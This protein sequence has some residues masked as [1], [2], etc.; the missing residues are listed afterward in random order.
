MGWRMGAFVF[1]EYILFQKL[2]DIDAPAVLFFNHS[3][4]GG[5]NDYLLSE[6][7]KLLAQDKKCIELAYDVYTSRYKVRIDYKELK[8][9]RHFRRL[10]SAIGK[11]NKADITDICINELVSY[12]D[13]YSVLHAAA[14]LKDFCRAKLIMLLHDYYSICPTIN[15]LRDDCTYCGLECGSDEGCLKKNRYVSGS[16]Y[17]DIVQW[18]DEWGKFLAGCDSIIA[19]SG[20]SKKIMEKAYG[21]LDN[22][23][24][25]PHRTGQMLEV[26][27]KRKITNDINIGILGVLSDRKGLR[28]VKDM[29][30]IIN[31][32]GLAVNIILIGT[33]EEEIA[34]GKFLETGKYTREQLPGLM[35][36]YDIDVVFIASVWPET[37]SYTAEEAMKMHMPVAVF[38]LGAP[39]ERISVYDNGLLI[40]RIDPGYALKKIM[41]FAGEKQYA[42]PIKIKVLFIIE[43]ESF[44]SRYRVD[45]LREHLAHIGIASELAFI[46]K[47]DINS[48]SGYNAVSIYRCTDVKRV[49]KISEEAGKNGIKLIYDI[50]DFI[51]DYEKIKH[52][53]F[54]KAKEYRNFEDYSCRIRKCM[55]LCGAFTA[56]TAA[57]AREIKNIFPGRPVI[58]C[59][60]AASLEMQLLSEAAVA[61]NPKGGT[62]SV[63]LGYFSGSHTHDGDWALIE[64]SI[65]R[66]MEENGN[67]KLLLAGALQARPKLSGMGNRVRQVPFMD[68][69]LLPKLLRSIDINL[70]P[71]EDGLFQQCKSENKWMEAGLV[72]IPTVASYNAELGSVM[73]DGGSAVFC[74]TAEDW[75]ESVMR[76]AG[77]ARL[78]A[79]IGANALKEVYSSHLVTSGA[80]FEGIVNEID[81]GEY[82]KNEVFKRTMAVP[83]NDNQLGETRF[84][85]QV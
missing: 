69:R 31:R 82:A 81:T 25:A 7:Q 59:R 39:A 78:R 2:L 5:A 42:A 34:D 27:K 77:D 84:K 46:D 45:H 3:L 56:S 83:G 32:N 30:G 74:R 85:K 9:C 60:N 61:G 22:I 29:L 4:G 14:H 37:F 12:P 33:C 50:D 73:K 65:I 62:G 55:E 48:I 23:E 47:V 18:R 63:V 26:R 71:L 68:W 44:S 17:R 41:E 72:G 10:G 19:F 58:V 53:D 20:D 64:E 1:R 16:R 80:N 67:I 66:A 6:K 49:R 54:L 24:V 28:V 8:A 21:C 36:S 15:L 40:D 57:L 35:Y 43:Y 70:M 52:L 75:H 11:V 76:L 38:N 79:E 13:V 51:F